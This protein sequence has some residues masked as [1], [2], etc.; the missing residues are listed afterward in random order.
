MG[1]PSWPYLEYE[2]KVYIERD[3]A[4]GEVNVFVD[5]REAGGVGAAIA[6]LRAQVESAVADLEELAKPGGGTFGRGEALL[7]TETT[8]ASA[9]LAQ[10]LHD[11]PPTL[12]QAFREDP[13]T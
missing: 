13:P 5:G 2:A 12:D 3:P 7:G 6:R 4:S 9:G 8:R 10:R 11:N 1:D